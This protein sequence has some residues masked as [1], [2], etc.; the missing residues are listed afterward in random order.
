MPANSIPVRSIRSAGR[1]GADVPDDRSKYA[2]VERERRFVLRGLPEDAIAPRTIRD[3]YVS[4]TGLRLRSVG[5]GDGSVV[6]KLGQK[7]RPDPGDPR[8]VMHT[9]L[10]LSDAERAS[11]S[12]LPTSAIHKTRH[13][14]IRGG[15]EVSV[16]LF[17]GALE[18]LI[19]AE[20]DLA[21]DPQRAEVSLPDALADV[22]DDE[23]FTGGAL[24]VTSRDALRALLRDVAGLELP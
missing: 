23:R 1:I 10:Y 7:V 22:S 4:G 21:S 9:T 17:H 20:V 24:A 2:K 8:V 16:D 15:L 6:H 14:M 12:G 11:L 5:A 18:G 13:R 19:L 3:G